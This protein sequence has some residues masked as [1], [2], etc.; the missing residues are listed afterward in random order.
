MPTPFEILNLP[1]TA[2]PTEIRRAYWELAKTAHPDA[3]GTPEAF[4]ALQEANRAAL[5]LAAATPC[6]TCKGRG[7]IHT[8]RGFSVL[9]TPCLPCSG[10][11]KK[12]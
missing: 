11:G 1:E 9:V 8:Q 3:G 7:V 4:N 5:A 10:I 12:Y 6:P 2:S